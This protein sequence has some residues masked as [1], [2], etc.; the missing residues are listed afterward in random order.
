MVSSFSINERTYLQKL[1]PK[2]IQRLETAVSKSEYSQGKKLKVI[3]KVKHD[4][5]LRIGDA[6]MLQGEP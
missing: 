1:D 6:N 5:D 3:P 4:D 2:T